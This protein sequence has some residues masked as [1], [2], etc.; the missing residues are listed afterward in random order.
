MKC[1][2][3]TLL[4]FS[5]FKCCCLLTFQW[6]KYYQQINLT[7]HIL[8]D[9]ASSVGED[10]FSPRNLKDIYIVFHSSLPRSALVT[11]YT[12]DWA[13]SHTWQ[14]IHVTVVYYQWQAEEGSHTKHI[15]AMKSLLA[16][17]YLHQTHFALFNCAK[18]NIFRIRFTYERFAECI[19]CFSN[20]THSHTDV[21]IREQCNHNLLFITV[22]RFSVLR[23]GKHMWRFASGACQKSIQHQILTDRAPVLQ[24]LF[25]LQWFESNL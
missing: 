15:Y 7:Q 23:G 24:S 13:F 2:S 11:S 25:C 3:S 9:A 17:K 21:Y 16:A 5:S 10:W 20:S 8:H 19:C 6:L 18:T 4:I 12:V 14:N 1:V 22:T